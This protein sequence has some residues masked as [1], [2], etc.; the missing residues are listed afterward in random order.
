MVNKR[1]PMPLTDDVVFVGQTDG[2]QSVTGHGFNNSTDHSLLVFNAEWLDF[3]LAVQYIITS[4]IA[5]IIRFE[6]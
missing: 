3:S 6:K 4:I 5:R 1:Q 2:S